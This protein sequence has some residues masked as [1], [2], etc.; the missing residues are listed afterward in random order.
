MEEEKINKNKIW[1]ITAKPW[2]ACPFNMALVVLTSEGQAG[3]IK[4]FR[5]FYANEKVEIEEA[6]EAPFVKGLVEEP[7]TA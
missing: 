4:E 6:Y 5:K 2:K 7:V 1:V 3:A